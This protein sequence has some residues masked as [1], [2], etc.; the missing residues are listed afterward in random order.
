[1][2]SV[3]TPAEILAV[4]IVETQGGD[5]E[6]DL[7][8]VIHGDVTNAMTN[9][10]PG[11]VIHGAVMMIDEMIDEMIERM[12]ESLLSQ[13][14]GRVLKLRSVTIMRLVCRLRKS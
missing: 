2:T 4:M 8:I 13:K 10:I 7:A 12:I 9:A 6:V 3:E 5:Q 14:S 1:M 11:G